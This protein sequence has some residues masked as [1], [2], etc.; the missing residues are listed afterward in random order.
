MARPVGRPQQTGLFAERDLPRV[1]PAAVPR[2]V[3]AL[4]SALPAGLRLG[5]CSWSFPGWAGLVYAS[6]TS[7]TQLARHG[8]GAYARH[9]L[10]RTVSVDRGYYAPVP[11]ED[12]RRYTEQV[13]SDFRFVVKAHEDCCWLRFPAHPRLGARAGQPNPRFLDASYAAEEVLGPLASGLGPQLG[14]VLFQ[15]PPQAARGPLAASRFAEALH[16]FLDS[17]RGVAPMA[18][19]VR[20]AD[21]VSRPV[22]DALAAAGVPAALSVHPTLPSLDVQAR[23]LERGTPGPRVIRW[24]LRQGDRYEEARDRYAPFDRR[25]AP[26]PGELQRI[27]TRVGAAA[28]AGQD[29]FVLVNNKAEGSAPH[30]VVALARALAG[31]EGAA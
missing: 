19:E 24:M 15:F 28:D 29:C 13:P 6:R 11:R 8:L 9:P 17:L 21:W 30:S 12:L 10:L 16:A 14:A 18:I 7:P 4:A 27:V 25:A 31:G 20:T 5:T 1:R 22:A 3:G 23:V 26:D 2:E